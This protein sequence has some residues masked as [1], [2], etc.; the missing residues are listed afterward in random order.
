VAI[1]VTAS[2]GRRA[3]QA[4]RPVGRPKAK[5]SALVPAAATATRPDA[6]LTDAEWTLSGE[7]IETFTKVLG[8]REALVETLQVA[9]DAPEVEKVVNHLL[10]P[11]YTSY[12]LR[13]VC[14]L[15]GITV[16]DVFAAYRKALI[17]RAHL[18]ATAI[19]A[20]KLPPIVEDVMVRATPIEGRCPAC[21]G[22]RGSTPCL[23]CDDTGRFTPEPD[24]DRQKLALELGQLTTKGGGL[25]IF[26]QQNTQVAT[27][28]SLSG[29]GT[30]ALEQL[31]QAVGS[32]L[33]T[34][35]RHRDVIEG[36]AS[37]VSQA[38]PASYEPPPIGDPPD[39]AFP[40]SD[41]P[42]PDDLDPDDD[43]DSDNPDD[44]D[45]EEDAARPPD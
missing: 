39:P 6:P 45:E 43:D 28:A 7:A 27:A 41:P 40:R 10:D 44:D 13:R 33:F 17:V 26:V 37:A 16:A 38:S 32:L 35:D 9:S 34:P 1:R 12:S 20:D 8:G 24:L 4:Q 18:R 5:T 19:I 2:G 42:D 3:D 15:V 31:H 11:R 30:G 14:H 22:T 25:G 36:V 21:Q 29:S 23:T